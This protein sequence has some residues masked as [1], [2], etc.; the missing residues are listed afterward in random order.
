MRWYFTSYKIQ[1]ETHALKRTWNI[2]QFCTVHIDHTTLIQ[3]SSYNRFQIFHMQINIYYPD[4]FFWD[5]CNMY[6]VSM[7][8]GLENISPD[9]GAEK[10]FKLGFQAIKI[11]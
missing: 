1:V 2:A 10:M 11:E 5:F 4:R 7:K 6:V 8:I 9:R 3:Q